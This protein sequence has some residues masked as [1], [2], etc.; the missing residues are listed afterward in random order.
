M[1]HHHD[2]DNIE[3]LI[4][5]RFDLLS[6]NSMFST[7]A[8]PED[9][10]LNAT[11]SFLG[12]VINKKILDAG[13]GKGRLTCELAKRGA[14]IVGVDIA[15][16]LISSAK[17]QNKDLPF[18]AASVSRLPFADGC[19]DGAL[20]VEVIE[21]VPDTEMAIYELARVLKP[22]GKLIVIDKNILSLDSRYLIPS[23][24]LKRWKE[25]NN[26]WMYPRDFPFREKWFTPWEI[27]RM[28]NKYCRQTSIR[29]LDRF[30]Y[31]RLK[32]RRLV[33]KAFPFL[34]YDV[35]WQGIK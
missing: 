14:Q 18:L 7:H 23:A 11:L 30:V 12:N 20:C 8:Q 10:E 24:L 15:Y 28:M 27:S 35:A 32:I 2:K 13:C 22:G 3:S 26:R 16:E 19:F 1:S 34:K 25:L 31:K 33:F 29:Y 6:D 9:F 17:Q 4:K 21:H 5:E